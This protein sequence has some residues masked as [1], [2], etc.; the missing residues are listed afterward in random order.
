[1]P[2]P[3]PA[4]VEAAPVPPAR[5]DAASQRALRQQLL[6]DAK[7]LIEVARARALEEAEKVGDDE[8]E[9]WQPKAWVSSLQEVPDVLVKVIMEPLVE[10]FA[11]GDTDDSDR[12]RRTQLAFLRHL[13]K[14]CNGLPE[15]HD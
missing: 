4:E 12:A 15:G 9:H 6:E 11:F 1:M 14:R 3:Q 13:G 8:V 5:L 7:G 2:E 10:H